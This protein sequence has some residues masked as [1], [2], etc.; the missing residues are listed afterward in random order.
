VL[1]RMGKRRRIKWTAKK[2]SIG[3]VK[4]FLSRFWWL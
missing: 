1:P 4:F 2:K 3:L